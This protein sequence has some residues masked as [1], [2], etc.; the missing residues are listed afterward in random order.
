M[1]WSQLPVEA[2]PRSTLHRK[3]DRGSHDRELIYDILDEGLVCHVG[4]IDEA[5]VVVVPTT[6]ARVDDRLYLHGAAANAMLGRLASGTV[7]CVTVTLLDG[8]VFSRSAFHHS[9]NYRS[10]ML[11]GQG[12]KVEDEAEKRAAVLGIIDHM[13][14]GRSG[15]VRLPS[16]SELRATSVVRFPISEGSAKIRAGGP[17]EE[18]EDLDLPIWAGQLPLAVKASAPVPDSGL[19]EQLGLPP[20]VR[21]YE[22]SRYPSAAPAR[23][24]PSDPPDPGG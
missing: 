5:S 18:H 22:R 8:L 12:A 14:P 11:F 9:M 16:P 24:S 23:L 7:A 1:E 13:A 10:V 4:F 15:D 21:G 19:P 17:I 6:Y 2:T 3:R 20:Y